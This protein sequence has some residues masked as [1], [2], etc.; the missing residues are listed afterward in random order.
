MHW[1][2]CSK[3]SSSDIFMGHILSVKPLGQYLSGDVCRSQSLSLGCFLGMFSE[4]ARKNL[5]G[6]RLHFL[7]FV[8]SLVL[9]LHLL[10]LC[11]TVFFQLQYIFMKLYRNVDNMFG[12]C[13]SKRIMFVVWYVCSVL[14]SLY[15]NLKL[16]HV[17]PSTSRPETCFNINKDRL[18]LTLST[19]VLGWFYLQC[20][21]T[22]LYRFWK[23]FVPY[24]PS[25]FTPTCLLVF[26]SVVYRPFRAI[27][28]PRRIVAQTRL[29]F[30]IV[31]VPLPRIS[32]HPACRVAQKNVYTLYSS[33]SLE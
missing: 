22:C 12:C 3:G 15:V 14:V 30:P 19:C 23:R 11:I 27:C 29:G 8:S 5:T 1:H 6:F 20:C 17:L 2:T 10:D 33:I 32:Y 13:L 31:P 9:R 26:K 18:L 21:V 28:R 25:P 7:L 24:V 16:I 4:Y